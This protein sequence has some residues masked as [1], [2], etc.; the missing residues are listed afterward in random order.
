MSSV[1]EIFLRLKRRPR[2]LLVFLLLNIALAGFEIG[3]DP[4]FREAAFGRLP[5]GATEQDRVALSEMLDRQVPLRLAFLPVRN[6]LG[7][8]LFALCLY[9]TALAFRP[10]APVRFVQVFALEVWAETALLL[11]NLATLIR[12]WLAPSEAAQFHNVPPLSLLDLIPTAGSLEL[13]AML[14]ALNLFSGFYLLMLTMGMA[15]ICGFRTRKALVVV[16][17][18]WGAS[19][20]LNAGALAALRDLL[21]LAL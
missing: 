21:H 18:V 1:E 19:L 9:F 16:L 7:W 10:L 17:S 11:G 14:G 12:E 13:D 4:L 15:A 5:A 3:M 2:W 6:V 8:G 20:V